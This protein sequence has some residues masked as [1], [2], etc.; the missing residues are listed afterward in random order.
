MS[1]EAKDS[2]FVRDI[3]A[4]ATTIV[5]LGDGSDRIGTITQED[6]VAR[7]TLWRDEAVEAARVEEAN[8]WHGF[9]AAIVRKVSLDMHNKANERIT[10]LAEAQATSQR[11]DSK[12]A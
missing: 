4:Q 6:A 2:A 10:H 3:I 12:D 7:L 11:E 5:P 9:M 8:L 1:T